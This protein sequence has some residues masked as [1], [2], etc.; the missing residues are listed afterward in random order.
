MDD[1]YRGPGHC[2][3]ESARD[4]QRALQCRQAWPEGQLFTDL[5]PNDHRQRRMRSRRTRDDASTRVHSNYPGDRGADGGDNASK[6]LNLM[7]ELAGRLERLEQSQSRLDKKIGDNGDGVRAN[8]A[9]TPPMNSGLFASG[10]GRGARMHIDSL[11]GSIDTRL[12]VAA[13]LGDQP[14]AMG[15]LHQ[16]GQ[17]QT[18]AGRYPAPNQNA[19]GTYPD[20]RQKKLAIGP[21]DGK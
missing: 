1:W 14:P 12:Y 6:L 5:V 2:V 3:T 15:P 13:D 21:Y 9:T 11:G 20:A 17:G 7:C 18:G 16:N 8:V 4:R 10:L 19:V